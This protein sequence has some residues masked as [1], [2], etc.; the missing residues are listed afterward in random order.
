[1]SQPQEGQASPRARSRRIS[2]A[3]S[4][5]ARRRWARHVGWDVKIRPLNDAEYDSLPKVKKLRELVQRSFTVPAW[6]ANPELPQYDLYRLHTNHLRIDAKRLVD[7]VTEFNCLERISKHQVVDGLVSA[8]YQRRVLGFPNH[9]V[10]GTAHFYKTDLEVLAATWVP[11]EPIDPGAGSMQD[12]Q[13]SVPPVNQEYDP[14]A[15]LSLKGDTEGGMPKADQKLVD[16]GLMIKD[17]KKYNKTVVCSIATYRVGRVQDLLQLYLL[18][19]VTR[20]AAY[21]YREEI[22]ERGKTLMNELS[23]EAKE[24]YEWP[25]LPLPQLGPGSLPTGS[26]KPRLDYLTEAEDSIPT[27]EYDDS[28]PSQQE[29]D[30]TS[31]VSRKYSVNSHV[32]G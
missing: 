12:P 22:M 15:D 1:M 31:D 29:L 5:A 14:T 4:T 26:K 17:I 25:P 27:D 21:E 13:S 24:T 8:P 30:S 32:R 16:A 23:E 19:R 3:E 2:Q 9:F 18:M 10:F 11:P 7:G 20:I 28:G 6:L